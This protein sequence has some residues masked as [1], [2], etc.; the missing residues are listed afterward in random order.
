LSN[1]LAARGW[2]ESITAANAAATGK[3]TRDQKEWWDIV[4][5]SSLNLSV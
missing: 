2:P 4:G 3:H 1:I 5:A